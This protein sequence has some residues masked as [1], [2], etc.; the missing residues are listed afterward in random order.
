MAIKIFMVVRSFQALKTLPKKKKNAADAKKKK[1]EEKNR[2]KT[3][4]RI[5]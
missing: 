3:E 1:I 2:L 4:V 5:G